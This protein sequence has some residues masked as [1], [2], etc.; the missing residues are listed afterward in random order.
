MSIGEFRVINYLRSMKNERIKVGIVGL[1]ALGTMY[2]Q[3]FVDAG[4]E[5]RILVDPDRLLRYQQ[6]AIEVNGLSYRFHYQTPQSGD[7]PMDLVLIAVKDRHLP[8]AI[9]LIQPI[10]GTQTSLISLLNGI[11]SEVILTETFGEG[12]VLYGFGVAM[13]AL[14]TGRKVEYTSKG[15]I[16]F[17]EKSNER[18][19]RVE[20]I[21]AWMDE[22]QIPYQIPANIQHAQWSKF[23]LNV[24]LNQVSALMR[25]PFGHFHQD[26]NLRNMLQMASDEAIAVAKANGITLGTAE[27]TH[28]WSIIDGMNPHGRTSMLQDVLDRQPTEVDIFAGEVVRQ[29]RKH[30]IPTPINAFLLEA[31]QHLAPQKDTH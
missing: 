12:P 26:Q 19:E 29:G 31:L 9:S 13:D 21:A 14:R 11:S 1:G 30:Q 7:A 20:K 28:M 27:I 25:A 3:C 10:V 2:A 15:W 17:G 5:V 18:T 24:G 8:E 22:A 4:F 23:M 6:E 16:V